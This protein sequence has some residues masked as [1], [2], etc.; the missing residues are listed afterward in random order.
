MVD[1]DIIC[2]YKA[3]IEKVHKAL[4]E[5]KDFQAWWTKDSKTSKDEGSTLRFEFNDDFCVFKLIK[6]EQDYIEWK[7]TD[8]KMINTPEWIGTT[9]IFQLRETEYGTEL[10][11]SHK[12]WLDETKC[13][14]KCTK[15]WKHFIEDSL[16][17][18]LEENKGKPFTSEN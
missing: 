18:Y 1:I 10:N 11:F 6:Q 5:E 3:P 13:Y 15:G 16:K 8:A 2:V 12:N 14:N 17:S 9:I 4:T 7:C